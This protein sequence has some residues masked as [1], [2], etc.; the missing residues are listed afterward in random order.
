MVTEFP[1]LWSP[2]ERR[3]VISQVGITMNRSSEFPLSCHRSP[4]T[5]DDRMNVVITRFPENQLLRMYLIRVRECI[6]LPEPPIRDSPGI[7]LTWEKRLRGRIPPS[8]PEVLN[9]GITLPLT[10]ALGTHGPLRHLPT[11]SPPLLPPSPH[12]QDLGGVTTWEP[13]ENKWKR[14]HPTAGS[15]NVEHLYLCIWL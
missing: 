8:L 15:L 14:L 12:L 11:P 10:L 3:D 6:Y 5:R 2:I 7:H 9:N 4:I 1:L 13:P